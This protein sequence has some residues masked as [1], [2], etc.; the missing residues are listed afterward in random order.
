MENIIIQHPLVEEAAVIGIWS[1]S[2]D[3]ELPRAYVVLKEDIREYSNTAVLQEIS[4]FV[5]DKVSNYK[6]L[7]GGVVAIDALPRNT[8]GK[9]LKKVLKD[10]AASSDKERVP[11]PKL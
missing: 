11:G 5:S 8:T 7:R 6:R 4:N 1:A 9:V 3:T 10:K 2:Q